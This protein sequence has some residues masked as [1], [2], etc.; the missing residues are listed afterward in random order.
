MVELKV[1]TIGNS[2]GII[3]P[4]EALAKLNVRKGDK[5]YLTESPAGMVLTPYDPEFQRQVQ[6]ATDL[7][8]RYKDALKELAK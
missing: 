4:K 1:T 3:L 7:M 6:A 2:T 5:L 8:D